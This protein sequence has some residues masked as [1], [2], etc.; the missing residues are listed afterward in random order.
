MNQYRYF[1]G[2]VLSLILIAC[3]Q[4]HP[5]RLTPIAAASLLLN[6]H[7]VLL[8]VRPEAVVKETG[9]PLY[10]FHLAKEDLLQQSQAWITFKET[11]L[12]KKKLILCCGQ[13][14]ADELQNSLRGLNAK[15]GF[16]ET[17][18]EWKIAGQPLK[19]KKV[20]NEK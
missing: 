18:S 16:I 4:N 10:S 9:T 2:C 12:N 5:S 3:T 19:P 7:A 6:Q 11:H 1:F 17:V 8:D 20:E 13:S 15:V 14:L